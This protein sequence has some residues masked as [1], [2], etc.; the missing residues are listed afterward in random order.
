MREVVEQC[1]LAPFNNKDNIITSFNN[2]N[3]NRRTEK[4]KT[5]LYA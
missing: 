4:V 2:I 5:F 1:S 3:V